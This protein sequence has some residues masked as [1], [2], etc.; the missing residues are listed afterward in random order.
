MPPHSCPRREPCSQPFSTCVVADCPWV[1]DLHPELP[2]LTPLVRQ[3][4]SV[5][6]AARPPLQRV[7]DQLEAV[8]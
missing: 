4:V 5:D 8:K 7:L 6:P 2:W 1:Q 3:C